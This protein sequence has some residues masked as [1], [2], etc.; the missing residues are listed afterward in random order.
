MRIP[1]NQ[2]TG[3]GAPGVNRTQATITPH[4][5]NHPSSEKTGSGSSDQVQL[6]ELV[7]SL[8]AEDPGSP[9]RE[10]RIEQLRMQV[11][12]GTYQPDAEKISEAMIDE[13]HTGRA[14]QHKP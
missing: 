4:S 8:K 3:V 14:A 7:A 11:A 9:E 10:A 5:T 6:S 12:A 2:A 1:D 13:A